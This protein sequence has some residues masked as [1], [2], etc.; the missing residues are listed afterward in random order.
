MVDRRPC[1]QETRT[2]D[3]PIISKQLGAKAGQERR[4][5]MHVIG[6]CQA[7][8]TIARLIADVKQRPVQ[9]IQEGL[10]KLL[11]ALIRRE[12][13]HWLDRLV[14]L[15]ERLFEQESCEHANSFMPPAQLNGSHSG[16][17]LAKQA[18]R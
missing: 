16:S 9:Q 2:L 3:F 8:P 12:R 11:R 10:P 7:A 13:T 17:Y 5:I 6:E 14:Q 4:D 15:H 1:A 18:C